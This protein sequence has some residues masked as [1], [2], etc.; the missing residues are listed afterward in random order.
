MVEQLAPEDLVDDAPQ[1]ALRRGTRLG[2][3][4]LLIPIAKGGMARVWA[5]RLHGQRGFSKTVAI[6]TILPHLAEE[7]E[8]E[9]MFLDE[10]RIAAGVHHPNV[11]EIY[12]LGEE[13]KT[14]Y[15]A[16]EWINGE[17]FVHILRSNPNAPPVIGNSPAKVDPIHAHLAARIISDAAMGLHAAHNLTDDDG[18]LLGVVHRDVSPHNILLSAEGSVKVADFGVAK[19]LGQMTATAAGQIKGKMAYMAPEQVEGKAIDRRSDIWSLGVV[20]YEASTGKKPFAGEGDAAV[21]RA[22]LMGEYIPPSRLVRGYPIELEQ[23]IVRCLSPNPTHRYSTAERMSIAIQE[24]L[25]R[26]G[27][28]VTQSHIAALVQQRV[29]GELQQRRDKIKAA[30]NAPVTED[31]SASGAHNVPPGFGAT[32]SAQSGVLPQGVAAQ[33]HPSMTDSNRSGSIDQP[34]LPGVGAALPVMQPRAASGG[35][36]TKVVAA[37]LGI[38]VA[39]GLAVGGV[40][41]LRRHQA[42]TPPALAMKATATTSTSLATPSAHAVAPGAPAAASSITFSVMPANATIMVD[43]VA[44]PATTRSIPRPPKG[45][46]V[47]VTLQA[48]G[49]NEDT[50]SIDDTSAATIVETLTPISPTNA[51]PTSNA[52]SSTTPSPGLTV[53][54]GGRPP[55]IP[56]NPYGK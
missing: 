22:I 23:I 8:F 54:V 19:A 45:K 3:Y 9:R 43:G 42:D 44:L 52:P 18:Q 55:A 24:F 35:S 14:L 28:V 20:L 12:E 46:S 34:A 16:M 38:A 1:A 15:L 47:A 30:L 10:A 32:P 21:M 27:S 25:S 48:S 49:F 5:A 37:I 29:G 41:L 13:G 17:S 7:P 36:A 50:L 56:T 39:C 11:C 31:I 40:V 33:R 26:S 4:E 51:T 6:K 2:R 53:P